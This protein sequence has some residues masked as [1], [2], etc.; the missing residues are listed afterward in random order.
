MIWDERLGQKPIQQLKNN[1]RGCWGRVHGA[2]DPAGCVYTLSMIR[3]GYRVPETL[4][5]KKERYLKTHREVVKEALCMHI[6]RG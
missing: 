3:V 6:D 4:E 5:K 2:L 1:Q